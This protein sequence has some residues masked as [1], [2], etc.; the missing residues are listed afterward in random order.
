MLDWFGGGVMGAD[1]TGVVIFRARNFDPLKLRKLSEEET[2]Y[3][4][5][6]VRF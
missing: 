3:G 2:K 4:R 1:E 5:V 6:R